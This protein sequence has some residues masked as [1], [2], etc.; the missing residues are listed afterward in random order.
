ML[1]KNKENGQIVICGE[2]NTEKIETKLKRILE[3]LTIFMLSSDNEI[4]TSSSSKT[5]DLKKIG[6]AI[7]KLKM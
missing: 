2:I 4:I 6:K 7:E 3:E 5:D 1:I